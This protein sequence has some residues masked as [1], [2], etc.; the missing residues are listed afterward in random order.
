MG[1]RYLILSDLHLCDV[2]EHSDGWKLYKSAAYRFDDEVAALLQQFVAET[3][4]G[5]E[6]IVVL[7][8][9]LFDFDLVSAVPKPAPWPVSRAER[10]RGLDATAKKSVWKL[11]RVLGDHPVLV[12]AL[13]RHL[14]AGHRLVYVLGNHDRELHFPEVEAAFTGALRDA[15]AADGATFADDRLRVEPWFFYVPDEIYA[16]HGNQHDFYTSFRYLLA[17]TVQTRGEP[18]IALPMGNLANRYLASRMGFFNPHASDYILNAYRYLTHWLRHYAF[19]RR[20]IF[21]PWLFGSLVVMAELMAQKGKLRLAPPEQADAL[22]G[23]AARYGLSTDVLAALAKLQ[24]APITMRFYRV[25]RELWIDRLVLVMLMAAATITLSLVPVPLWLKLSLP[26][27]GFPLLYLVYQ[28]ITE[29]ETVFSAKHWVPEC[30]RA[31]GGILPVQLVTFGHTHSPRVIPLAHRL[32]F[33]D[34]GA[35]A[36]IMQKMDPHVLVPGFRNYLVA[37][38]TAPEVALKLACWGG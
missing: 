9:D 20:T 27:V 23:V 18:M 4:S 16:E 19:S 11:R 36:P 10:I 17:P 38:F 1:R 5:V 7:N 28:Q 37:D 32:V 22:A 3:P 25:V 30:A 24:R 2:E 8:G 15:A 29:G 14:A 6:A 31:I 13:A 26:L 21:L 12:R 33:A 34:T 35:W